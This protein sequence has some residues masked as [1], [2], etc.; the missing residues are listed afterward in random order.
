MPDGGTLIVLPG[1]A[2]SL[3]DLRV[4]GGTV[5]WSASVGDDPDGLVT[6]FPATGTLTAA[7]PAVIVTIRMSQ[8]YACGAGT[9]TPCPTVTIGNVTFAVWTGWTLPLPLHLRLAI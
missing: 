6:V 7:T 3:V 2:G 9:T 5:T 8:F 4:A 1:L